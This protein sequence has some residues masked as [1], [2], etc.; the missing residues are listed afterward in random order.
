VFCCSFV[1]TRANFIFGFWAVKCECKYIQ[2]KLNY[3]TIGPAIAQAVSRWL[4]TAEDRVQGPV[5]S[6]EILGGQKGTGAGFCP[7]C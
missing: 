4:L 3:C 2:F 1:L 5:I 7:S 6:C